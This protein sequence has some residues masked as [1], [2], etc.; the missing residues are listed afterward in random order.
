M[1]TRSAIEQVADPEQRLI[2]RAGS[3]MAAAFANL[4]DPALPALAQTLVRTLADATLAPPVRCC[5]GLSA[6]AYFRA[7]MDLDS[8]LLAELAMRA[9]DDEPAL[10]ERLADEA[11]HLFVQALYECESPAHAE[12]L[13]ARRVASGRA[14]LPANRA[15]AAAA[16]RA[17]RTRRRPRRA[18]KSRALAAPPRAAAGE[19]VAPAVVA[20]SSCSKAAIG[21]RSR[22]RA[23]PCAW[24]PKASCRSAGWASP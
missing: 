9:L 20:G 8:L 13:R 22:M 12:A 18:G 14:M 24:A 11:H 2:A 19:L 7:R 10:G 5:A 4:D 23:W 16:R 15:Q 1:A 17:D 3:L 21:R 6:A